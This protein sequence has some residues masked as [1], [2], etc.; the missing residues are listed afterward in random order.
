MASRTILITGGC[1]F[2]GA[3]LIEELRRSTDCQVRVLDNET[4]GKAEWVRDFDV[5]FIRGDIRDRQVLGQALKGVDTVVHLAADTRVMDSIADP[6]FNFET[7][8]IGS[9]ELLSAMREAGCQRIVN[10]STG[11]AILGEVPPPVHEEMVPKPVSPY[12]A[13]K[14]A[15]EGYCS[16]FSGAYGMHAV[17]LRFSNVY[18]VYS[19]HK[20]SVVAHFFKNILQ[21]KP[22]TVYGDGSQTRDYVFSRDLSQGIL[23]AV[24]ADKSGVFQLGSGQ[25]VSLNELIDEIRAV[26]GPE[27]D[28]EVKYEDFREGEIRY[29]YCDIKKAEE[30]LGFRPKTD[31]RT[32][33]SITWDW[34][35]E[36]RAF[37]GG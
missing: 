20:G 15:V 34:F 1:G 10:A 12:G 14:L 25:P 18:G 32:G 7:N 35:K 9:F 5:D 3:N 21:G 36:N 37:F 19:Y 16:A 2:V 17:S 31:L 28:F 4:M 13:S 24:E 27:Y 30:N 29:T 6:R 26:V 33:L 8:V 11:G 23:L 22:L